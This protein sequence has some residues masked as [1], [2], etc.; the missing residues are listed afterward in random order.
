MYEATT[1]A[2]DTLGFTIDMRHPQEAVL[3]TQ[4][5]KLFD[6]AAARAAPCTADMEGVTAVAQTDFNLGAIDL[7]RAKAEALGLTH[8]DMPSGAGHDAM[9]IATLCPAGMILVPCEGGISHNEIENAKSANLAA[10]ARVLVEVLVA[11]ANR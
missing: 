6:I 2:H 5:K 10:G 8:M 4:E 11:L 3:E 1:D 7:V 9:H